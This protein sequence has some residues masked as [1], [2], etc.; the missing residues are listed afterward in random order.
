M[1]NYES[2][3]R[4]SIQ[5]TKKSKWLWVYGASIAAFSGG[6]GGNISNATSGFDSTPE[7]IE[8]FPQEGAQ[9]LSEATSY[10]TNWI[11]TVNPTTWILLMISFLL[12]VGFS[13]IVA[14]IISNW[15]KA[16]LIHG[17]N[18]AN[19]EKEVNLTE[20]SRVGL[21]KLKN[22][23]Y[24]TII[25]SLVIFAAIISFIIIAL[26]ITILA[27]FLPEGGPTYAIYLIFGILGIIIGAVSFVILTFVPI[28]ADRLIVLE[29]FKPWHAYKTGFSLAKGAF[30]PTI[31]M[32]F[33]NS[34]ISSALG[35]LATLVSGLVVG[36]PSL[37]LIIWPAIRDRS[38]PNLSQVLVLLVFIILFLQLNL[39][40][41]GILVV[42]RY[43]NWNLLFAEVYKNA[44]TKN[45]E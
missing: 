25:S 35:C 24:L 16:A 33:I 11:T 22:M 28:Y 5:L 9:V 2:I 37:F 41:R 30:L 3:I 36:A 14:L 31:I 12:F 21:S 1:P 23:I 34:I 13:A 39:L 45:E 15:A 44:T 18:E 27:S 4:R 29:N 38:L 32:G 7:N 26:L 8:N 40:I 20:T 10:F 17:L 43:G 6:S 42:F 19:R